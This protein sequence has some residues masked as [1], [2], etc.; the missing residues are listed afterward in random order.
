MS[1][2]T[3]LLEDRYFRSGE[4]ARLL[5]VDESTVKRWADRGLIRCY[6]TPGGHRKFTSQQVLEFIR[7]YRYEVISADFAKIDGLL[8]SEVR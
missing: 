5:H 8:K 2:D 6:R 1:K 7:Q 4:L 3:T